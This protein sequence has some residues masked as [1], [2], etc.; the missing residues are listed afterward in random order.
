VPASR[1][2]RFD[3]ETLG[4]LWEKNLR[5]RPLRAKVPWGLPL[6]RGGTTHLAYS[7]FE[8]KLN[9]SWDSDPYHILSTGGRGKRHMQ[10]EAGTFE[11]NKNMWRLEEE[12]REQS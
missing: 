4:E 6:V 9:S 7:V 12:K 11:L 3:I 1:R 5:T 10:R 8:A 2:A